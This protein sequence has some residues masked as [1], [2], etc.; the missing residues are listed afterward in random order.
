M[1]NDPIVEEIHETR[2]RIWKECGEDFQV[3]V[4][5]LRETEQKYKDRL[6]KLPMKK[7]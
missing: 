4:K 5:R 2:R 7:K 3:L 1:K 6:V